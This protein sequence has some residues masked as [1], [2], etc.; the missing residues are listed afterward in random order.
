MEELSEK[1]LIKQIKKGNINYFEVLV[2]KYSRI[3][4][5]Y[6]LRRLKN[7]S[8]SQDVVQNA[9]IKAYKGLGNFDLKQ[10][11]YPWFFT[12][13]K[14]EIVE[15]IRKNKIHSE[16]SDKIPAEEAERD[17]FESLVKDLKQEY[18]SVLGLYF[19]D[20]YSYDEIAQKL[21]KNINTVKTLIRRAKDAAKKNYEKK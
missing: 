20:G 19:K 4:Y 17:E 16:L 11:F 14:N 8:D 12:I 3:V 2:N 9:F 13:V 10:S 6:T 5:Y 7:S 15:F 1:E 21:G 18:K